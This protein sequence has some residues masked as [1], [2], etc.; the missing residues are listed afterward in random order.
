MHQSASKCIKVPDFLTIFDWFSHTH[1]GS[2]FEGPHDP[3]QV[4]SPWCTG[5]TLWHR[6]AS[7]DGQTGSSTGSQINL[8]VLNAGDFREWSQSSLWKC[9]HPSNPFPTHPIHSLRLAR[10]A[11]DSKS[12]WIHSTEKVRKIVFCWILLVEPPLFQDLSGTTKM[13]STNGVPH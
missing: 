10:T 13:V 12:T 8:L 7:A 9:H 4:G 11:P 2:F 6:W 3:P 1:T 5:G